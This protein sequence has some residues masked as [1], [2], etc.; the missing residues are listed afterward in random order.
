MMREADVSV[1][2]MKDELT[3]VSNSS[4]FALQLFKDLKPLLLKHGNWNYGRVSN[5]IMLFFYKNFM[6]V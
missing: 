5:V 4:D 2:L 3:Q 1:G 6:L